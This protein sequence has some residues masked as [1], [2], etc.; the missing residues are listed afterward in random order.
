MNITTAQVKKIGKKFA[1]LKPAN[2]T[3]NGNRSLTVK[4]AV[5]AL[6]PTLGRM[7]KRGFGTQRLSKNSMKKASTLSRRSSPNT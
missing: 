3:L 2:V 6:A 7:K 1:K 4:E 5:F